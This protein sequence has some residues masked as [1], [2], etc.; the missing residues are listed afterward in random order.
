MKRVKIFGLFLLLLTVAFVWTFAQTSKKPVPKMPQPTA[1]EERCSICH[2]L[3]DVRMGMEKIIQE[4]H[5]KAG[6]KISE[7]SLKEVEA[8]FTLLPREEPQKSL[9]QEKCGKCHSLAMV[10]KAHQTKDDAEMQAIIEKMAEKKKSGISKEEI[11]KIHQSMLMLNEIYEPDV[12]LKEEE[13]KK[14]QQN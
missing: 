9:F 4:M 2:T 13:E 14:K 10:V 11:E 5:Q 6:I 1:F 12:E 7:Q 8:T 3:Q